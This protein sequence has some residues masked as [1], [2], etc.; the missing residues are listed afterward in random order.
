MR[1]LALTTG[2]ATTAA[3]IFL[4]VSSNLAFAESLTMDQI[5]SGTLT[6]RDATAYL[7]MLGEIPQ[8]CTT[9]V[10]ANDGD[11]VQMCLN[12][13]GAFRDKMVELVE[14]HPEIADIPGVRM[15]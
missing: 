1:N 8:T 9:Y 11:S 5:T 4:C 15:P 14:E 2:L 13:L 7:E 12:I 6:L 3:V 10:L